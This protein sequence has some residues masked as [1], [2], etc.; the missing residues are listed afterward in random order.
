M[1]KII[2]LVS[3]LVL[4]SI[5][6]KAL[7]GYS[8]RWGN[9]EDRELVHTYLIPEDF[10]GCAWIHYSQPG[11]KPLEIEND[12]VIFKIPRNGFLYTSTDYDTVAHLHTMKVFL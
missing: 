7:T 6:F 8:I 2:L 9:F 12:E 11:E 5:L 10:A 3:S 1:K 4:I